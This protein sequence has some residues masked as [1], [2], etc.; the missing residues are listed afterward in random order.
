M[1]QNENDDPLRGLR[2]QPGIDRDPMNFA[3]ALAE[4]YASRA[5]LYE[6]PGGT[7]DA[8]N[9]HLQE[10]YRLIFFYHENPEKFDA[11]GKHEYFSD[12]GRKPSRSNIARFVLI[13]TMRAKGNDWR[14]NRIYK[15][16]PVL[17][18]FVAQ[19]V[20]PD[21]VTS[22]LKECGG[23]D[24]IYEQLCAAKKI[25]STDTI[26]GDDEARETARETSDESISTTPAKRQRLNIRDLDK[27]MII[28]FDPRDLA[29]ALASSGG[30]IRFKPQLADE[31]GWKRVLGEIERLDPAD[32]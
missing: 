32:D 12:I 24:Q 27:E 4:E 6:A 26:Q 15:R 21:H 3:E 13:F 18:Q 11:F 1:A 17:E 10:S 20:V 25:R 14:L 29:R 23:V 2:P 19:G 30:L 28:E 31:R 9:L 16:A 7:R 8:L 5:D 22:L